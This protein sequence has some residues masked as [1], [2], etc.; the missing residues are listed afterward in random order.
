MT[1]RIVFYFGFIFL[2]FLSIDSLSNNFPDKLSYQLVIRKDDKLLKEFTVS[3][4]ISIYSLNGKIENV[5]YSEV[6]WNVKTDKNGL[7]TLKVGEGIRSQGFSGSKLSDLE[8]SEYSYYIK[9][10]I[11]LTGKN[12]YSNALIKKSQILSVPYAFY[13]AD[14]PKIDVIDNLSS[15]AVSAAL[16]AN[17]GR[18]LE[19]RKLDKIDIADNFNG[20]KGKVLSADRGKELYERVD[21]S[22]TKIFEQEKEL[23]AQKE[24]LKIQSE[25]IDKQ[26]KELTEEKAELNEQKAELNEEKAE[27]TK[28]KAELTKQKAELTG[29]INTAETTLGA[30]IAAQRIEL[31]EQG[32]K[33]VEYEEKF[34]KL[35]DGKLEVVNNLDVSAHN[36]KKVLSAHQGYQLKQ[37]ID[38]K[39]EKGEKGDRGEIGPAGKEGPKGT[40]G[41]DGLAGKEGKQGPPGPT[42]LRGETGPAGDKGEDG[43]PGPAGADGKEGPVG[44]QGSIGPVG[45]RG[46]QG[47]IGPA[48][49][50]GLTGPRGEKGEDGAPGR[51]GRDGVAGPAGL[52]G[53]DGATGA[54]GPQGEQGIPGPVNLEDNLNSDDSTSALSAK[55]G[56]EL[57]KK[58]LNISDIVDNLTTTEATKA[59]SANQGKELDEKIKKAYTLIKTDTNDNIITKW[60]GKG[61][62]GTSG[63]SGEKN[64]FLGIGSG[65]NVVSSGSNTAVGYESLKDVT[66]GSNNT[67]VGESSLLKNTTGEYNTSVGVGSLQR[68]STGSNNTSVGSYSLSNM[69]GG[70][71]NISI[72]Y[73]A[74]A[75]YLY[76]KLP[77]ME[78]TE[79]NSSIFIGN[80]TMSSEE[81]KS[82]NEI[83]IGTNMVGNGSNTVTIGNKET[84]KTFLKGYVILEDYSLG[85]LS[86]IYFDSTFTSDDEDSDSD[87]EDSYSS[88]KLRSRTSTSLKM[89]LSAKYSIV[90]HDKFLATSDKRIKSIKGV[91][92]RREDL[93]KLLNIE[94][95]DYTMIDSIESGVMPF[96]KV[97]AQQVENILPQVININKGIIP[98]VYELAKSVK[99]SNEG[100]AIT[101]N[102][103]HDFSIGDI[104][105]IIIE[106]DGDRSVKV[107]RVIDSN[108]FLTEEVL[109]SKNKVFIYGKEVD[110]LRSVDYDGLT[111]LN[112]SA[113]QAVYDRVVGL[114]KESGII[115]KENNDIKKENIFLKKELSVTKEK[116]SANEKEISVT[117]EKLSSTQ[118]K[119]DILIRVLSKSDVLSKENIKVLIKE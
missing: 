103:A 90:T 109:D 112:I 94:I 57:E 84:K 85:G 3:I 87:D 9:S 61:S 58:K 48:G 60:S 63:G 21:K 42:G 31:K 30:N 36:E 66:S 98:N 8:W 33:L 62:N 34:K 26:E 15:R 76:N 56:K 2:S 110:D 99:T 95:T 59:L 119:L 91:S 11:D 97:I 105:K 67:S 46:L 44:P 25:K 107:K 89:S 50:A 13:A 69:V 1:R 12:N 35:E 114:E 71:D 96:K 88:Y 53:K 45:P 102:K 20:G 64:I 16:S 79:S 75:K 80:N 68:N 73:Y 18:D 93:K 28:Q 101:T 100:S 49:A 116:L 24:G 117:K 51:D 55:Q 10:E 65:N 7:A 72:G 5:V 83:V 32:A 39:A 78:L 43:K 108:T 19:E 74:G 23:T 106:N 40:D 29:K 115:K 104:V 86:G 38:K 14:S 6:H 118:K 47:E 27:L 17:K 41:K 70:R 4:R 81:N 37:M 77:S 111:T 113:T 54:P 22:E 52:A 92:D 82:T